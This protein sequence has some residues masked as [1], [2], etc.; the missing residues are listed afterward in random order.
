MQAVTALGALAQDS[1]LAVF[2]LLVERGPEGHP[3]G[4]IGERLGIPGPTLS[5]HLRTLVQAGL[6]TT[7]RD[8]RFIYY[9]AAFDQMNALVAYLTENCCGQAATCTPA[10]APAVEAP[11]AGA[12]C[13]PGRRSA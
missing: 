4:E 12:V 10:C 1:R 8:G 6:A 7:R 11:E 5:F 9:A 3:A 13:A 2:R